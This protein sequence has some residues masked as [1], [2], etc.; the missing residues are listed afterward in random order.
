M[1]RPHVGQSFRSF[2]ASW[3]QWGQKRRFSTAHGRRE[4]EG[5]SGSTLPTT[6]S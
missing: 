1:R 4:E 3:P 5:A 2:W 6:S